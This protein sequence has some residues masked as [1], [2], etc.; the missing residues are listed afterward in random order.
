MLQG[1]GWDL[2]YLAAYPPARLPAPLAPHLAR[3]VTHVSTESARVRQA[4]EALGK[5]DLRAVGRLMTESHASLRDDYEASC[6][7]A[8]VL[9]EAA[10]KLGVWGARLT[11][12]GW[13]GTV[14]MLADDAVAP[15]IAVELQQQFSR[16]YGRV[17][18]VW[19]TKA[20]AGVKRE[21]VGD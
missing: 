6:E 2:P 16:I 17:P 7:E 11:G 15:R 4:V 21:P 12:A 3:R 8:D 1:Q 13:G 18:E 5:N 9:V 20:S 10:T 19:S 14:V